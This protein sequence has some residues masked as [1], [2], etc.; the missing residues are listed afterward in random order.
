MFINFNYTD[1]LHKCMGVK[2]EFEY[3]I[4]GEAG[5]SKSII[6]GHND[7]PQEPE[8]RLERLGGRFRGL[9]YVDNI[10]Y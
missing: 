6:F 9:Y 5:D 8:E 7:H 2:E 4:H 1:T 3:H 10:L